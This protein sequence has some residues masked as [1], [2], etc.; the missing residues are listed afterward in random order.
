MTHHPMILRLGHAPAPPV[1]EEFGMRATRL[2]K[3]IR[4]G[5][6]VP[7]AFALSTEAVNTVAYGTLLGLDEILACF[8]PT[9]LFSI[10]SSPLNPDWGGPE[11]VLNVGMNDAVHAH[12]TA[13][14][15]AD[16][17][18]R[19]YARFIQ[20][21]GVKVA[22]LEAEDF[23]EVLTEAK[24]EPAL[25]LR[26][27]KAF[28]TQETEQ[29]FPQDRQTQLRYLLRAMA[30]AWDGLSARIL[31]QAHGAPENAGL[32]LIVQR[33]ALGIGT[34]ESGAGLAQFVN[35]ATG[36][37]QINGRYL[38]QSQGRD[39][40][41][42]G[43]QAQFLSRDPRGL[44]LEEIAPEAFAQLGK[45]STALRQTF[46]DEHSVEFTIENGTPLILDAYPAARNTRAA[47]TIATDLAQE[48]IITTDEALMRIDPLH[49]SQM[50]HP[51]I[52]PKA[53]RHVIASGI[54]ASPGA[55]TGRVVF[56]AEE[57]QASAAR[58][59]ACILVRP[60]TTPEDIRGMHSAKAIITERGGLTSH[61]AV[62]A[63]TL[64]VPC[65]TGA[66]QLNI[67]LKARSLA[68]NGGPRI[69]EG[70]W[71]TVDGTTGEIM[72]G[73]VPLVQPEIGG[74]FETF[75]E[76]ADA[77]RDIEV[78]ANADTP[79]DAELSRRF[80]VDGIGLCRT[81]HM[82]FDPK[83][84]TL[85]REVIMT[86]N[87][88]DRTSALDMLLPM[89][90]A[91]FKELFKIMNG[92][93]VCIR[94][95][96]PPF[97]EFLPKSREECQSLAEAM[98]LPLRDVMARIKALEE[99]NPMLGLRGVRLGITA[100]EI[101]AMQ[102]RAIF[103]AAV[104][105]AREGLEVI[106]EIM[107]PLVSANREVELV[108]ARINEVADAVSRAAAQEID[109][110][111][112]VMVETPRAALR[113]GDLAHSASFLSF[114]TNDLTQ[115]TYGLSRDDA[116]RFMREYVNS[117]V[118]PE[119][120][121]LSLDLEAVGEL[122]S[123]AAERAR[124]EDPSLKLGLCGEHGGDPEAVAFCRDL[125][126]TYISCAPFRTPI[127]RLAAAQARIKAENAKS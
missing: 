15:G 3:L 28:Y 40:I 22:R 76:W 14:Y 99:F 33:M 71:I 88:A 6:P 55:A 63:R 103:E 23:E 125:G 16:V 4:H 124:Q 117:G 46:R 78:R 86:K 83:R 112:G 70:D 69:S 121:F 59:E 19:L 67:N 85:M 2:D 108:R 49:L 91:D 50:L 104:E 118:Y 21:F 62:I 100:P 8:A 31:R 51:Q 107:I 120:P 96:D 54:A 79:A 24:N 57:A 60:E 30:K 39:A 48:G 25:V 61:A 73:A 80:K 89:Q 45:L 95:L 106:P 13:L 42:D 105:V 84:L 87:A 43:Q 82:F 93:P 38:A 47:I 98:D 102:T 126:F 68:P 122:L 12:F 52:D 119:D 110:E 27:F 94:L 20:D 37:R 10:R 35:P 56:N 32:G 64:G 97:H 127:A 75:M 9:A 77:K 66:T 29:S 123:I 53:K 34:G 115:M 81:E 1:T 114:G 5:L 116:G 7:D 26:A 44:S 101:Y 65:I 17:A 36:V 41:Q 113:A 92:L 111:L 72:H 11:T 74:V 58:E 18:D 109:F 90:R